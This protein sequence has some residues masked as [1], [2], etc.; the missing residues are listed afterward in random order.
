[1]KAL[2]EADRN[3]KTGKGS[4]ETLLVPLLHRIAVGYA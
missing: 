1:M 3:I 2:G 4:G